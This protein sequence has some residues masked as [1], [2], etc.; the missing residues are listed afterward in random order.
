[1]MKRY[2]LSKGKKMRDVKKVVVVER[3]WKKK[4]LK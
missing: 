2:K 3:D 1:M 4:K